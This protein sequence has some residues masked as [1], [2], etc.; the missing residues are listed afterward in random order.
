MGGPQFKYD[1]FWG[2]PV[3]IFGGHGLKKLRTTDLRGH[4]RRH[5]IA[6]LH[7][8]LLLPPFSAVLA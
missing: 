8:R 7:F 5:L 4:G 3:K 1:Y 6:F 2:S